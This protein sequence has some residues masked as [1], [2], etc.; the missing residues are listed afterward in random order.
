MACT[1]KIKESYAIT[2]RKNFFGEAVE[3][4]RVILKEISKTASE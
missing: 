2:P 1:K 3:R 4:V